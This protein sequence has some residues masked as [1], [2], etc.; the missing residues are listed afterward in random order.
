MQVVWVLLLWEALWNILINDDVIYTKLPQVIKIGS[1]V[2]TCEN[3][4]ALVFE[5]RFE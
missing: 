3:N 1:I 2:M 5:I 4:I